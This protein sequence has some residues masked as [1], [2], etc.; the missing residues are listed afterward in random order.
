VRGIAQI[1]TGQGPDTEKYRKS[2]G[3]Q[4]SDAISIYLCPCLSTWTTRAART[5]TTPLLAPAQMAE[6]LKKGRGVLSR[7]PGFE[8]T[9]YYKRDGPRPRHP[10]PLGALR[11]LWVKSH[12]MTGHCSIL[13][14]DNLGLSIGAS[15]QAASR[16]ANG[17]SK[18]LLSRIMRVCKAAAGRGIEFNARI[19]GSERFMNTVFI[20]FNHPPHPTRMA[21]QYGGI[22]AR[23]GNHHIE[24]RLPCRGD[25]ARGQENAV[26]T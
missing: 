25:G 5:L 7:N 22:K 2:I 16:S 12:S 23:D 9:I 18:P 17:L 4:L 20:T 3:G 24:K 8:F 15:R 26:A 14:Q 11:P 19:T 21:E 13:R 10:N 1:A 6:R